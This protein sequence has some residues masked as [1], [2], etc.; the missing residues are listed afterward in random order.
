M[1]AGSNSRNRARAVIMPGVSEYIKYLLPDVYIALITTLRFYSVLRVISQV[2]YSAAKHIGLK[3]VSRVRD[4]SAFL[5][6]TFN[7][8]N[9]FV[10]GF[11]F[12]LIVRI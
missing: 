2:K 9:S 11:R 5:R 4:R 6:L 8:R 10:D 7:K 3:K 12:Y 1:T